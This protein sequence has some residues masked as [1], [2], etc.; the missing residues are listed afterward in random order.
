MGKASNAPQLLADAAD[1]MRVLLACSGIVL[2]NQEKAVLNIFSLHCE[3][4]L[5]TQS[6]CPGCVQ[7]LSCHEVSVN[8]LVQSSSEAAEPLRPFFPPQTVLIL[9]VFKGTG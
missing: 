1:D 6:F 8:D 2:S 7:Q 4:A 5:C 9:H 3:F